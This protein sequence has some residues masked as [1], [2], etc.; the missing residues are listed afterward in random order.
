MSD[1]TIKNSI[2]YLLHW[3]EKND[4]ASYDQYD[5]WS[6]KI[7][8]LS[9]RI[10]IKNRFL[11]FPLVIVIYFLDLYL[12]KLRSFI[13]KE[14]RSAEAI[15]RIAL[16]YFNLYQMTGK[17]S[18]LERGYNLLEWLI[19]NASKTSNGIG[20]GLHFDWQKDILLPKGTP[21]VTLTAYSTLA[22]LLGYQLSGR[23]EYLE[24]ATKTGDF[25]LRDLNYKVNAATFAVSYT[26]LDQ[27]YVINANSYAALILS[28]TSKYKDNVEKSEIIE[29]LINYIL[30]QQN[31]DGSWYYYDKSD[32]SER[33]NFI[34]CF[35]SCFILENLF[36]IWKVNR[37]DQLKSA[38]EK[39]YKFFTENFVEDDFSIRYYYSYPYLSGIKIDMRGCAESIHCLALLSE[40][41]PDA[42]ELAKNI[43][44]WT[45]TNMQDKEGYFYFRLYKFHKHKMPY[46]RWVQAPMLDAL[47]VLFNKTEKKGLL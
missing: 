46:V 42:L 2:K 38:I 32:V 14:S 23:K 39:G 1:H 21:C 31:E 3:I 12:P 5:F 19:E 16:S 37:N 20:W 33:K 7:G 41:F 28:E 4:Y 15:P 18:Y 9:K 30:D 36:L 22:F 6:S 13:A 8:K 43:A 34:D 40:I 29:K 10:F 11:G 27:Y 35:H 45:I 25:V 26:P 44:E 17:T 47:I 24:V